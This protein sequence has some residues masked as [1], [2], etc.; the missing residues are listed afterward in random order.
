MLIRSPGAPW[1]GWRRFQPGKVASGTASSAGND[2]RRLVAVGVDRARRRSRRARPPSAATRSGCPARRRARSPG[3]AGRGTR[4]GKRMPGRAR[5]TAAVD[6]AGTAE[7]SPSRGTAEAGGS[8]PSVHPAVEV[9]ERGAQ[10]RRVVHR[11]ED[12]GGPGFPYWRLRTAA[13]SC[14]AGAGFPRTDRR[15][16]PAPAPRRAAPS[17][18]CGSAR[19]RPASTPPTC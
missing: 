9:H 7:P 17:R 18:R 15:G 14:R 1:L 19:R 2:A 12:A 5:K 8:T 6:S 13:G 16:R 3:A 10:Q 4:S 11:I